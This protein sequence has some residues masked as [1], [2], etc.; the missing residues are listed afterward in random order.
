MSYE[1]HLWSASQVK[2][3]AD[4]CCTSFE[5][6]AICPRINDIN[7]FRRVQSCTDYRDQHTRV[8][9]TDADQV[10][11][12]CIMHRERRYKPRRMQNNPLET[13]RAHR[14]KVGVKAAAEKNR[15]K[16]PITTT[17]LSGKWPSSSLF[18]ERKKSLRIIHRAGLISLFILRRPRLL[19]IYIYM[20]I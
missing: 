4:D 5:Y 7:S 20:C 13:K 11:R 1:S 16:Q 9:C 12:S 14:D 19:Y 2:F 3:L 18:E 8:D 15:Y 10:Y 17:R 6:N